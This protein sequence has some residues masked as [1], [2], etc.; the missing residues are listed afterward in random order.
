MNSSFTEFDF[1][2]GEELNTDELQIPVNSF[3]ELFFK[4]TCYRSEDSDIILSHDGPKFLPVS[5]K[6]IRHI[7]FHLIK[8][9]D[10]KG[11]KAGDTVILSHIPG[12][13]ELF[14]ILLFNAFISMG[15]RT[16]MPMFM[17]TEDLREWYTTCD[18]KAVIYSA[19]EVNELNG[20]ESE[21][22]AV[23]RL[24]E[25]IA[26]SA[27]S[28]FDI[29]EDFPI[30]HLLYEEFEEWDYL[31]DP[32]LE[33]IRHQH[34]D[35][36]ILI[37]T[38]SG[39]SGKSK[40]I[41]FNE[42]TFLNC[43]AIWQKAGLLSPEKLGGRGFT[44]IF[45]QIRSIRGYFN[46]IW[47]GNPLCLIN[48]DWF[49]EKPETVRYL[50]MKMNP[51]HVTGGY[52]A[53]NL[54]LEMVRVFPEI[55]ESVFQ[56]FKTLLAAG[57][58]F[59]TETKHE[60]ETATGKKLHNAYGLTETQSVIKTLLYKNGESFD[61][62]LGELLPG[63]VLGF[64]NFP[65]YKGFYKL[66][67]KSPFGMSQILNSEAGDELLD[68]N[69]F[70]DSGDIVKLDSNKIY[71]VGRAKVDFFKDGY[72]V[73]IPLPY[74]KNHYKKLYTLVEHI[75][76][77]PLKKDFGLGAL[78]FLRN[79]KEVPTQIVSDK[80]QLLFFKNLVKKSNS[81]LLN[82]LEPFEFRHRRIKKFALVNGLAPKTIKGTV[83]T[84]KI[85]LQFQGIINDIA[86][87]KDV[88]G[89]AIV[90]VDD[91][92][93]YSASFTR[94]VNPYIGTLLETLGI[95][96]TYHKATGNVLYT[97]RNN[98]ELEVLDL[99][100]G[101]GTNLLGHNNATIKASM[102]SFIEQECVAISDQASIQ[103][104]AG[105]LAENLNAIMSDITGKIFNISFASSGSEAME[106][107]LH[108]AMYE[109]NE[110]FR[111]MK[112]Q[113]YFWF[114]GTHS[115]Q[116]KEIWEKNDEIINQHKVTIIAIHK[117]FHGNTSGAR[118]FQA[119]LKKR[120]PFKRLSNIHTIFINDEEDFQVQINAA[121]K[122]QSISLNRL[123]IVGRE[124]QIEEFEQ[125]LI[126]ASV[127]EP[128]RGEGGIKQVNP[129][130]LKALSGQDFP[131]IMDE[132]Q[133]G[134]GRTGSFIASEGIEAD[135]YLF[136]KA[137]GGGME[138]IA[139]VLIDTQRYQ[140][141]FGELYSSTYANGGLASFVASKV[142]EII[143]KEDIPGKAKERGETIRLQLETIK[144][145]YPNVIH[146]IEGKGL[147]LG[148][149]FNDYSDDENLIFRLL[150]NN[151]ILGYVFAGYLLKNHVIRILPSLSASNVLR[152][153]PSAFIRDDQINWLITAIEDLVKCVYQRRTYDLFKFLMDG[154][155][156]SDRVTASEGRFMTQIE[157]P[158][159][160]AQRVFFLS[161]FVDP[162]SELCYLDPE[163]FKASATG[164]RILFNK[165]QLILRGK[166][167]IFFSKNIHHN[168]I[169]FTNIAIPFDASTMEDFYKKG[170]L[171]EVVAKIQEA[172]DYAAQVGAKCIGLGAY[173]SIVTNN[174]LSILEPRNTMV[175]TGN[176][177]TVAVGVKRL[178]D[179]IRE[180]ENFSRK[181]HTLGLLGAGGNIGQQVTHELISHSEYFSKVILIVG[182]SVEK[183]ESLVTELD[184]NSLLADVEIEISTNMSSLSECDVISIMANTNDPIVFGHHISHEKPVIISDLSVPSAVSGEVKKMRNVRHIA[185]SSYV[186]LPH[187]NDIVIST[188]VP[189]GSIYCCAA[190]SILFG[191]EPSTDIFR[192]K[193]KRRS[194]QRMN[195]VGM[196]H[197]FFDKVG[198]LDKS[199]KAQPNE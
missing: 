191:L 123:T 160:G 4:E 49:V 133:S 77:I 16:L 51:D 74:M 83:S 124:V 142:L 177:M 10:N 180:D 115:Q 139:A 94:Y 56:N 155:A 27:M 196:K 64:K 18:A 150:S 24:Q 197:G 55:K 7:T 109:W 181:K 107:A 189:K 179:V 90:D 149:H 60:I 185:F 188:T 140:Q 169:H 174:G 136:S 54:L 78:L 154:D 168:Q 82:E 26:S 12:T 41:C 101:Y 42:Q 28:V 121:L 67:I 164:L 43:C 72:G 163:L 36:E 6:Q 131:L 141:K 129:K 170:K 91:Q 128:I 87:N 138:R 63:V 39:T 86:D 89:T 71:Y 53:F 102:L 192:G 3:L 70:L 144:N 153:E 61:G 57:S 159:E 14:L 137:L 22:R 59:N 183:I 166:P 182:R 50:L 85:K 147:M 52:S 96:Y 48:T 114:A 193:I 111:K 93:Y 126:I 195:E 161:H 11:F 81:T 68:K 45:S 58:P 162:V 122:N 172:V 120:K 199:W 186:F 175:L 135:Y 38:T 20:Y 69:G 66:F 40:L 152:I 134:L 31:S 75:E 21:K 103:K 198:E 116:L 15:I 125:C 8:D 146:S 32:L 2:L 117:S 35:R 104:H 143:V 44:P 79:K 80:E 158:A 151:D 178:I 173:T 92:K 157:P 106:V 132:I 118:S 84:G 171:D 19:K 5:L 30:Q 167:F 46:S 1:V 145:K 65:G 100:G 187:D 194:V 76:Y 184:E 17:E 105:D 113:Q 127:A 99:V 119:S 97:N 95:D 112:E 23:G 108:H 110:K 29:L 9:L 62:S 33:A 98:N 156:F 88:S 25:V 37:V 130:C 176:S 148:I 190:E 47:N 73:K 165:L 13:N 34:C